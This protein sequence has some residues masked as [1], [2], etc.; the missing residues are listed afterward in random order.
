[1]GAPDGIAPATRNTDEPARL[2]TGRGLAAPSCSTPSSPLTKGRRPQPPQSSG[3]TPSTQGRPWAQ[4]RARS[5]HDP[6]HRRA[7]RVKMLPAATAA[8]ETQGRKDREGLRDHEGCKIPGAPRGRRGAAARL[9]RRLAP[10][11]S[12]TPGPHAHQKRL[13]ASASAR[14]SNCA[15]WRGRR[16]ARPRNQH[17]SSGR[18]PAPEASK[19]SRGLYTRS[20]QVRSRQL[21]PEEKWNG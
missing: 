1:M 5:S 14:P 2:H 6:P 15:R 9:S 16:Q 7:R 12:A 3:P 18:T 8:G 19:T 4:N 13:Q 10:K 17:T 11:H 21:C 20:A